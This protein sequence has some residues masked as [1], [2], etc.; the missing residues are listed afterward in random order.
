MS[1]YGTDVCPPSIVDPSAMCV[2]GGWWQ[3]ARP[4]SDEIMEPPTHTWSQRRR[5]NVAELGES[6]E[7]DDDPSVEEQASPDQASPKIVV[8]PTS[9]TKPVDWPR[10]LSQGECP[11]PY[12]TISEPS[13]HASPFATPDQQPPSPPPDQPPGNT[14]PASTSTPARSTPSDDTAKDAFYWFPTLCTTVEAD[15]LVGGKTASETLAPSAAE[16]AQAAPS[17]PSMAYRRD[18]SAGTLRQL[19]ECRHALQR[20]ITAKRDAEAVLAEG[21]T[22]GSSEAVSAEERTSGSAEAAARPVATAPAGPVSAERPTFVPDP[23]VSAEKRTSGGAVVVSADSDA[24]GGAPLDRVESGV[25]SREDSTTC[26]GT[27]AFMTDSATVSRGDSGLASMTGTTGSGMSG[28]AHGAAAGSTGGAIACRAGS[29]GSGM[30]SRA[31]SGMPGS[32]GSGMPGRADSGMPGRAD[33]G[34]PGSTDRG[35]PGSTGSG[36]PGSGIPGSTD[37]GMPGSTDSGMPGR[38]DSGIPGSTDRG[39][40]GST[41]RGMPGS[42]DSGIPGS[43]DSGMPGSTDRGMPGSTVSGMPGRADSGS[44]GREDSGSCR[45]AVLPCETR[46]GSMRDTFAALGAALG[47]TQTTQSVAWPKANY[48]A[49]AAGPSVANSSA[50]GL[51]LGPGYQISADTD[52]KNHRVEGSGGSTKALSQG[53]TGFG[54]GPRVAPLTSST[55]V[56]TLS[57]PS[58]CQYPKHPHGPSHDT[59]SAGSPYLNPTSDCTSDPCHSFPSLSPAPNPSVSPDP[60]LSLRPLSRLNITPGSSP[61]SSSSPRLDLKPLTMPP[62]SSSPYNGSP[63]KGGRFG[64]LAELQELLQ[65]AAP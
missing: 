34:I 50:K 15:V 24:V 12:I 39:M 45:S 36:M 51:Q 65:N 56:S 35:M 53:R 47:G 41:D 42:T 52:V 48:T 10:S 1:V 46:I 7:V 4:D 26:G 44:T 18:P 23:V 17:Q 5:P 38:A 60:S 54:H 28:W 13:S 32:A 30:P 43:T 61:Q 3:P 63:A 33:S 40:P 37:S 22:S 8:S 64:R 49:H 11:Q 6:A 31:D 14:T 20:A 25:G 55:E 57:Y 58:H 2:C 27:M 9:P 62:S 16:S 59:E 29:R 19:M 21:H